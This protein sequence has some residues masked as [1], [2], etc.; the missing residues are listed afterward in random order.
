M[1][2]RTSL[3]VGAAIGAAVVALSLAACAS[4]TS[5]SPTATAAA[6]PHYVT[7]GKL[8]V[9]TGDPGYEPWIVDNKPENGKGFESAVAYA[10]AAKLGFT[11]S[12]VVWVRTTFDEAITPGPKN[13]DINLQQFSG[14]QVTITTANP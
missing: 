9:A 3:R 7:T 10:V 1:S 13:F 5:S 14:A 6:K 12:D 8:T 2:V 4:A 11:A